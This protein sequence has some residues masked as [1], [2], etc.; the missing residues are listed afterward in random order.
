[1]AT[2]AR[3]QEC[4]DR[5]ALQAKDRKLRSDHTLLAHGHGGPD[6]DI[7]ALGQWQCDGATGRTA[8]G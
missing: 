7:K 6:D 8:A 3:Q 2:V 5:M 4:P 1:V